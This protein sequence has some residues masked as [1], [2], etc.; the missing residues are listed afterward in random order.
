MRRA[1][2]YNRVLV[3]Y[4]SDPT[5][6]IKLT[7]L[8]D[9]TAKLSLVDL[10]GTDPDL[11]TAVQ[12]ALG[13]DFIVEDQT[14][15]G[16]GGLR[17]S[18]KAGPGAQTLLGISASVTTPKDKTTFQ[19]GEAPGAALPRRDGEGEALYRLVRRGLPAHGVR[20]A[21]R[22]EPGP[23]REHRQPRQHHRQRAPLRHDP[24]A[25][26]LRGADRHRPHLRCGERD[27]RK[28]KRRT[29]PVSRISPSASS[30]R[31]G[32]APPR[33]RAWT[34]DRASPWRPRSPASPRFPV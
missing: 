21:H 2:A 28:S 24:S 34:R 25:I 5:P 17:I 19:S 31:R 29:A 10:R 6:S 33:P 8:N 3:P 11:S 23:G 26:P 15:L 27:R 30:T 13:S 32:P 4:T 12:A 20:A 18:V 16:A 7:D 9:P 14:S 1:I 22:R